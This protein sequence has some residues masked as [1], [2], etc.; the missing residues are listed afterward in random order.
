MGTSESRATLK[1]WTPDLSASV[2]RREQPTTRRAESCRAL[3]PLP[4]LIRV[5]R[6]LVIADGSSE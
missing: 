4:V 3:G 1:R 2:D 6:V 5:P